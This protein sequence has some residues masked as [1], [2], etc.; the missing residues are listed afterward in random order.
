M[1][2]DP[3]PRTVVPEVELKRFKPD[4]WIVNIKEEL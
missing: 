3:L 2:A 1:D 4:D